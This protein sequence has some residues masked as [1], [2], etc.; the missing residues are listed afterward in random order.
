MSGKRRLLFFW[1]V[2]VTAALLCGC[3]KNVRD[4]TQATPAAQAAVLVYESRSFDIGDKEK[5]LRAA[6]VAL[7]EL[8]FVIDKADEARAAILGDKTD[9]N[10]SRIIEVMV[11]QKSPEQLVVRVTARIDGKAVNNPE[12]YQPF[13]DALSRTLS[14]AAH[15]DGEAPAPTPAPTPAPVSAP[16]SAPEPASTPTPVSSPA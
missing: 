11:Q 7:Q 16:V 3:Q 5:T 9:R 14:L 2:L 13:F 6:I 4:E 12:Y 8:D 10:I 1:A 15:A